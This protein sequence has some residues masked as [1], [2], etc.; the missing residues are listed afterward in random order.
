LRCRDDWRYT[1]GRRR[2]SVGV[3]V[4]LLQQ[5]QGPN[6]VIVL[7]D[8]L[9]KS[10]NSFGS[11]PTGLTSKINVLETPG[12]WRP[13]RLGH[14]EVDLSEDKMTLTVGPVNNAITGKDVIF[15][16]QL[17]RVE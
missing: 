2:L 10:Y 9:I 12:K 11:I 1:G 4:P 16:S 15:V 3:L 14:S 13:A 5:A 7:N 6:R 8:P 17:V